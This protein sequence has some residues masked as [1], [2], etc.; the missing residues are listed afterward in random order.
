M[1]SSEI[2]F[3]EKVEKN[4]KKLFFDNFQAYH[5]IRTMFPQ[6]I[7]IQLELQ[8]YFINYTK[9]NIYFSK[10]HVRPKDFNAYEQIS[11]RFDRFLIKS[12]G[13]FGFVNIFE[14]L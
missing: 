9:S 2:F 11:L 13:F 4:T 14:R 1:R 3:H 8:V 6:N 7:N 10:C 5:A 12:D